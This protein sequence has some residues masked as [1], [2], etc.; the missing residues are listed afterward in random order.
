MPSRVG[1]EKKRV[2]QIEPDSDGF[3]QAGARRLERRE[4]A[5]RRF[6]EARNLG[7]HVQ[8]HI[9]GITVPGREFAPDMPEFLL[10]DLCG[11]LGR[12]DTERR[13]AARTAGAGEVPLPLHGIGQS[14][15]AP[16]RGVRRVY[17]C[18]RY[19]VI[20]HHAEA[21]HPEV[22]H[23]LLRKI[24]RAARYRNG[25]QTLGGYGHLAGSQAIFTREILA[26]REPLV[27][28]GVVSSDSRDFCPQRAR[29]T[30]PEGV[31]RVGF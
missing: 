5:K 24:S 22:V 2:R 25:A 3:E 10:V 17:G 8:R 28:C 27:A 26:R 14:E 21:V 4:H 29:V 18:C 11:I 31:G 23:Q 19:A 13:I 9:G 6:A 12:L 1:P 7:P 15:Q 30:L 20:G 16:R